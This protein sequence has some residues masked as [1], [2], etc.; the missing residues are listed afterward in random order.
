MQRTGSTDYSTGVDTYI[1]ICTIVYQVTDNIGL[2]IVGCYTHWV[3]ATRQ[4]LV[5][6][7]LVLETENT[8]NQVKNVNTAYK[9]Q[10]Q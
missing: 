5:T 7:R 8:P 2:A 6:N 10:L 9:Q 4:C 3:P 1:N